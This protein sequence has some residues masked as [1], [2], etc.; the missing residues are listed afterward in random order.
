FSLEGSHRS[1]LRNT[2]NAVGKRGGASVEVVPA[3]RVAP[4]LPTL[5]TIS[6]SWLAE[7]SVREKGFS[8]GFFDEHYL[9]NFPIAI[10][11][12]QGEIVAFSNL[13]VGA[14]KSEVSV[15]LMRFTPGAPQGI[16]E[17][18]FIELLLWGK[19]SGYKQFSLG[20]APLAGLEARTLAPLW[21]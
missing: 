13:W 10:V 3:E 19:E 9:A 4:L 11:R 20:M 15:D 5:R 8:L 16:M 7:K 6:D 17:F 2:R 14:D 1:K 21:S 12:V 18:L